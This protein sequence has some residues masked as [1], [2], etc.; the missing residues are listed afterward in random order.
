MLKEVR[1]HPKPTGAI[2]HSFGVRQTREAGGRR[3][4]LHPPPLRATKGTADARPGMPEGRD[5]NWRDAAKPPNSKSATCPYTRVRCQ[6]ASAEG[7]LRRAPKTMP[8]GRRPARQLYK[9]VDEVLVHRADSARGRCQAQAL[10]CAGNAHAR[11]V[12]P[13]QLATPWRQPASRAWQNREESADSPG[14]VHNTNARAAMWRGREVTTARRVICTSE[15]G[16][17]DRGCSNGSE[18]RH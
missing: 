6:R 3:G 16:G 18:R 13:T 14:R 11:A 4:I 9:P 10:R 2:T 12:K 17:A 1:R 15:P 7:R 8:A 5:A